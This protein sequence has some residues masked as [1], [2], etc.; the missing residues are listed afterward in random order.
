MVWS[1]YERTNHWKGG[2]KMTKEEQEMMREL[3]EFIFEFGD[4][5]GVLLDIKV[6]PRKKKIEN[7]R[8]D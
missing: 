6:K 5:Y 2:W 7:E 8:K 1:G 3:A 4:R